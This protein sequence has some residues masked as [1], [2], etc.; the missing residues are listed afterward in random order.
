MPII[1][2]GF[3]PDREI[4]CP[5]LDG[6]TPMLG[7]TKDQ[8]TMQAFATSL[9]GHERRELLSVVCLACCFSSTCQ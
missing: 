5:T 1:F 6:L 2:V 4:R 8:E 7:K 9:H 3:I